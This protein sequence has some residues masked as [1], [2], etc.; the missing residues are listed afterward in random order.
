MTDDLE[1]W[2]GRSR[3]QTAVL[4]PEIA[5]RYAAA[6]GA[7]L[8]V[9]ANFPPLGHWAYFNDA[10]SPADL[11]PDGHPRRG[12]FLP[13]VD[14][15][16]RMFASAEFRFEAPL[17]L[18]EPAELGSTI[19]DIRRRS[20]RSGELV[21]V[22]VLREL[23]Q[24]GRLRLTET[25]TIVYRDA[26]APTPP[27]ADTGSAGGG[28]LWRPNPVDLFRFSAATYN[29][30]RIHYDEAYAR[31]EE[32]YP[33]LVVHGPFTAARLFDLAWRRAGAPI[34][35]FSFRALAPMFVGQTIMLRAADEPDTV[36]AVRCDGEVGMSA[37]Y[38]TS[39]G[40]T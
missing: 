40:R 38:E 21:L 11:G 28:E 30:H 4:D 18:G 9:E 33:G 3:S 16:R 5:R 6:M 23:T 2:I 15:P 10:V 29:G 12:L 31:N 32:G 27:V 13:P 36:V 19:A 20:G 35:R 1:A 34:R 8:E 26:G 17:E 37:S 22:D 24:G 7:D 14:L 39:A 25:Q